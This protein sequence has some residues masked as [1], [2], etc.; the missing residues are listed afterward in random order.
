VSKAIPFVISL[1][2]ALRNVCIR[3]KGRGTIR[4]RSTLLSAPVIFIFKSPSASS[5][6]SAA[7]GDFAQSD[8]SP[9]VSYSR[10]L[11]SAIWR[12]MFNCCLKRN[13]RDIR[14]LRFILFILSTI[15]T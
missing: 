8:F 7:R 13:K 9:L 15:F 5:A 10:F 1:V 6:F 14:S 4:D 3:N 12:N 11:F 2:P